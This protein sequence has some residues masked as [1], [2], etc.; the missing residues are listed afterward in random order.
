MRVFSSFALFILTFYF[1]SVFKHLP[2]L[3]ILFAVS[4]F[5]PSRFSCSGPTRTNQAPS[6]REDPEQTE[7]PQPGRGGKD[8]E[9]DSEPQA[10][11]A[12]SH[13]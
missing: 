10:F 8:P 4:H 9:G 11:S 2:P 7:D 13:N 3:H 6:G 5:I 12:S 1:S